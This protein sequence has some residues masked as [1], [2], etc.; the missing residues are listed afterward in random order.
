MAEKDF[1]E[2]AIRNMLKPLQ[3]AR[4]SQKTSWLP[5]YIGSGSQLASPMESL[6][7]LPPI[8]TQKT[9]KM[10]TISTNSN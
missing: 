9:R 8:S 1:L 5:S 2:H 4:E 6:P 10:R 3:Q 7:K